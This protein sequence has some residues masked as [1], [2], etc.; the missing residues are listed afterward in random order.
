MPSLSL[1]SLPSELIALVCSF[2]TQSTLSTV[3]VT[4]PVLNAVAVRVLYANAELPSRSH[5][6]R[7]LDAL[8]ASPKRVSRVKHLFMRSMDSPRD[9]AVLKRCASELLTV[10]TLANNVQLQCR[11]L[12]AP[13]PPC[14]THLALT[15]YMDP[16]DLANIL[17]LPASSL[18]HLHIDDNAVIHRAFDLLDTAGTDLATLHPFQSF[19]C[20]YGFNYYELDHDP[21][22]MPGIK[23]LLQLT[24]LR[25]V[26]VIFGQARLDLLRYSVH[27]SQ[28]QALRDPRLFVGW[29]RSTWIQRPSAAW[30]RDVERARF[31]E[32]TWT[33]EIQ[34]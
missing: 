34:R 12:L 7:F 2:C 6:G 19:S 10:T 16:T 25:R 27:W 24:C 32:P 20:E 11:V 31:C 13:V 30:V 18:Q 23:A 9:L 26:V 5:V 15:G 17:V 3:A 21:D 28:L 8:D 29:D 22:F 4:S 33:N 14:L 1:L